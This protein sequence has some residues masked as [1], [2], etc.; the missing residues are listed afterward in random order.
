MI[1]A[2]TLLATAYITHLAD[3]EAAG[4]YFAFPVGFRRIARA[5]SGSAEEFSRF[6]P[7]WGGA[8]IACVS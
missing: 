1:M 5:P 2:L 4:D 3:V 7:K 8:Y 6:P